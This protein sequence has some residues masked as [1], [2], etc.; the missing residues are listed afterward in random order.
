MAVGVKPARLIEHTQRSLGWQI[1]VPA[2]SPAEAV[3]RVAC[4]ELTHAF[5]AHLRLPAWLHEGLAM[6]AVD[7]ALGRPHIQ[8]ETLRRLD[9]GQ[10]PGERFNLREPGTV[11]DLYARGYWL[12][13]YLAEAHAALL[14]RLLAEPRPRAQVEAAVARELGT[15][16]AGLWAAASAHT[17]AH[18]TTRK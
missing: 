8:A 4:H 2:A 17:G 13:R 14:R 9:G 18:F 12:T 10:P 15:T 5:S 1:F 6:V 11:L 3:Q 16:D 7:R